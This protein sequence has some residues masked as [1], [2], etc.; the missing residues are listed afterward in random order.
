MPVLTV[1]PAPHVGTPFHL[2]EPPL[3][4]VAIEPA[5]EVAA[6]PV[7]RRHRHRRRQSEQLGLA[8]GE[9]LAGFLVEVAGR[10]GDG[11]DV[12]RRHIAVGE[13]IGESG[14]CFAHLGPGIGGPGVLRRSP[15]VI[16]Q[17][18]LG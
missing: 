3:A 5:G 6:A 14:E 17:H 9:L 10:V 18:L 12:P 7:E 1:D 2:V 8:L 15:A 16:G 11:V 13:G 4:L